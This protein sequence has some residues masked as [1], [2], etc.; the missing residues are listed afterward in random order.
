MAKREPGDY[1]NLE[2]VLEDD[3]TQTRGYKNLEMV[4]EPNEMAKRELVVTRTLKW[5]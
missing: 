3:E 2:M 5:C 1:K 4:R